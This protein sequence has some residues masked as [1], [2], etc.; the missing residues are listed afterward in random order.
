MI[1]SKARSDEAQR[2]SLLCNKVLLFEDTGGLLPN[3]TIVAPRQPLTIPVGG[4]A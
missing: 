3:G 2:R 1:N 4:A